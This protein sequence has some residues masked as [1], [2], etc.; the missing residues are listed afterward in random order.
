M[1]EDS[2]E[3]LT[4]SAKQLYRKTH[5]PHKFCAYC[6]GRNEASADRCES[7]DK[8]IS[9]MKIPESIPVEETPKQK[10]RN[11]PQQQ[12]VF[13]PKA[14][15]VFLLILLILAAIILALIFM[16]TQQGKTQQGKTQQGKT[17]QGG[18]TPVLRFKGWN[19]TSQIETGKGQVANLKLMT[20][21]S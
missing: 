13:T 3:E 12:K 19:V 8:N 1:P 10:P 16:K 15:V 20:S 17:Q 14:I 6:G 2:N 18:L 9:W 5:V 21:P 7:C 4:E 11:L